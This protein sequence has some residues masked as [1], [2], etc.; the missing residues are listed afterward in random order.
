MGLDIVNTRDPWS[1]PFRWD[2]GAIL[3]CRNHTSSARN[4]GAA[5]AWGYWTGGRYSAALA[6][7]CIDGATVALPRLSEPGEKQLRSSSF[8]KEIDP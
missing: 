5:N 4:A 7:D 3:T 6:W 2:S 8:R 1:R